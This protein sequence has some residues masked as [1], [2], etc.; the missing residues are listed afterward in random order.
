MDRRILAAAFLV[1]FGSSFASAEPDFVFRVRKVPRVAKGGEGA[2][3][4]TDAPEVYQARK[5]DTLWDV[6]ARF[7]NSPRSWPELWALNPHLRNPHR[8]EP[9]DP[10]SLRRGERHDEVRLP[11]EELPGEPGRRVDETPVGSVAASD[12]GEGVEKRQ[13]VRASRGQAGHYVSS[14]RVS[15]LGT[16]RGRQAAKTHFA[17]ND[18]VAVVFSGAPPWKPG[19]L[20]T[21]YDD[22]LAVTHPLNNTF[23][24]YLVRVLGHVRIRSVSGGEAVGEIVEAY[25]AVPDGASVMAYRAPLSEV[26]PVVSGTEIT[27]IVLGGMPGRTLL[28]LE[29]VVFLDRGSLHG[30]QPGAVLE[31]P[32][33]QDTALTGGLAD[34]ARPLARIV[35]ISVQDKTAMGLIWS[36]RTSVS[37]GQGFATAALSP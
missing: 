21:L 37:A 8:L 3:K 31:I 24:G 33:V 5:G 2:K 7:W 20:A 26:T 15:P 36:S 12:G 13:P 25:D 28:S 30:L 35:V 16:I 6:A 27:G 10:I 19:E 1:V 11:L 17:S 9:G 34:L 4:P 14:H 32:V 23:Q 22:S 18:D 29:D